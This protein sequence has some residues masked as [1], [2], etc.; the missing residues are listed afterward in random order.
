MPRLGINSRD[1]PPRPRPILGASTAAS[2]RTAPVHG[3]QV[4]GTM[5]HFLP[6]PASRKVVDQLLLA[7]Q[8][9]TITASSLPMVMARA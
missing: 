1:L 8:A 9:L 5:I 3:V 7:C 2:V 6:F 4:T